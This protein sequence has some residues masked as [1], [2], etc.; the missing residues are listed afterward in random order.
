MLNMTINTVGVETLNLSTL[1]GALF[2][3]SPFH[4]ECT[5]TLPAGIQNV[6][7]LT[8][9]VNKFVIYVPIR[10]YGDFNTLK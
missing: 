10:R 5:F 8:I 9:A 6:L 4:V 1:F 3:F 7:F 2:V